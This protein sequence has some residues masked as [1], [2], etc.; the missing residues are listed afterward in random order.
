MAAAAEGN[1]FFAK[2]RAKRL[3]DEKARDDKHLLPNNKLHRP[4]NTC[5]YGEI[6]LIFNHKNVWANLQNADPTKIL[7]HIHDD[8]QWLPFVR[9]SIY[10]HQWDE[11]GE[12]DITNFLKWQKFYENPS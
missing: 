10:P 5:E 6:D 9:D 3:L 8:T 2:Q 12:E 4:D 1:N 11:D 7:Y